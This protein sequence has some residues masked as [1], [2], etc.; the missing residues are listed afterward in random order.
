M[1]VKSE[2]KKSVSSR[3]DSKVYDHL[4]RV[5][6]LQGHRFF[7]RGMSYKVAKILEDWYQQEEKPMDKKYDD[8][9]KGGTLENRGLRKNT[10]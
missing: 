3:V 8:T 4:E 10:Y 1:Q 7:D 5:S 6:S 2:P 9:N